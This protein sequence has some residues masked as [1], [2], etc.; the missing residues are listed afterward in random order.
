MPKKVI[1]SDYCCIFVRLKILLIFIC[2]TK[3]CKNLNYSII[4]KATIVQP[5]ACELI[6]K[7]RNENT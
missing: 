6:K 7:Q 2:C 4:I 3:N 5:L 1:M